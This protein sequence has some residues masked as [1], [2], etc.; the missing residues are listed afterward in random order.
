MT[1]DGTRIQLLEGIRVLDLSRIIAGPFCSQILGDMGAEVIKIEQPG[2]GDGARYPFGGM[3]ANP[4]FELTNHGKKSVEI[5]LKDPRGKE[6]F[7]KLAARADVLIEGFR[8][9]VMDRLGVGYEALRA[10]NP[11]L[12]T[13]R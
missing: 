3:G 4:I 7:L 12:I 8:P 1:E 6:A 11:R 9:D 5:D 13:R 2:V 10:V